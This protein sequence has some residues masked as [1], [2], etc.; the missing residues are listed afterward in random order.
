[1][2]RKPAI[3]ASLAAGRVTPK[4]RGDEQKRRR[5]QERTCGEWARVYEAVFRQTPTVDDALAQRKFTTLIRGDLQAYQRVRLDL[6]GGAT[7]V[8]RIVRAEVSSGRSSD[9][10]SPMKPRR[11]KRF[12]TRKNHP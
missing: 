7:G 3:L 11:A 10:S 5:G 6:K 9:P 2:G 4:L 8:I 12:S 1:V